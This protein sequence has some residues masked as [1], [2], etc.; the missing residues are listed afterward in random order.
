MAKLPLIVAHRGASSSAPEN[1]LAAFRAAAGMNADGVEFD[2]QL[3]KDGVPVVFHD[4]GLKRIAGRREA[5]ADLSSAELSSVDA[6]S[7]FDKT[8]SGETIPTFS[9]ALEVLQDFAGEIYVELK[10]G[11]ENMAAT[12]EAVCAIAAASPLARQI[13]I[14]SFRPGIIP[15]VKRIIPNVRA[16]G[17]FSRDTLTLLR[18]KR[19]IPMLANEFGADGL[20]LHHSLVS[21]KLLAAA[22]TLGLPVSV[23]TVD[24]TKWIKRAAE[25]GID[26]LITNDPAKLLAERAKFD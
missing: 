2:V 16:Y 25:T 1:T 17:L 14:K 7:W 5:V 15:I 8:Y 3:A 23:W 26:A 10:C 13:I 18:K 11:P 9:A 6:G 20:S 19:Y 22:K 24:D 4:A 12:A 21:E